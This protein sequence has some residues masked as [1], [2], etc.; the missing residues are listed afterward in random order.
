[1]QFSFKMWIGVLQI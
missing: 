1:M